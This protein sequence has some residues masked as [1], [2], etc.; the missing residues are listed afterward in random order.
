MCQR[1]GVRPHAEDRGS[2]SDGRRGDGETR[3][4]IILCTPIYYRR[5]GTSVF[6]AASLS[7]VSKV[8]RGNP[9]LIERLRYK[10]SQLERLFALAKTNRSFIILSGRSCSTIMGSCDNSV[11]NRTL[12]AS[13]KRFLRSAASN[14]FTTS[15][16]QID[17]TNA[18]ASERRSNTASAY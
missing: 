9:F 12:S 16:G 13:F 3:K 17:G 11:M 7:R 15:R 5:I 2:V 1:H 4:V 18:V 14:T 10:A 6:F 8:A